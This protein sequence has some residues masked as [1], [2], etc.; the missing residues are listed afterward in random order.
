MK[1]NKLARSL[2][3]IGIGVQA[4]GLGWAQSGS[5]VQ[6]V[7]RVEITG[8]SI[9]RLAAEGALP[10][11]VITAEELSRKG[12]TTAEQMLS[13]M[14]INGTGADSAVANN[15]VFGNDTDRLTGGSANANLRGLGPGSTLV[16]LNG[17][18]VS[19]HGMSGGAVDLNAIPMAAVARV[20]VLKDGASAIYGTDAIGG[21]INFI[22]KKDMQGVDVAVTYSQP[23]ESSA[24]TR[25]R[26][27]VTG[28]FGN[29]DRDRFNFLG[30][31]TLDKDDILRGSDRKWATGFQPERYLS[32]DSSSHPFANI[33]GNSSTVS[34][35]ALGGVSGTAGSTIGTGDPTK[36][37]RINLL[38][39]QG[40]CD[41]IPTGVQYQPQL[42]GASAA[43][44][45]YICNTDYGAQ[46]MLAAPKDAYNLVARG[47]FL[48]SDSH[49]A[50]IELTASRTESKAELTPGQFSTT[51]AAQNHYPVNGPH[52]LNLKNYGVND[53]DPTKAIAYRWRMQ[54]F[55][56]RVIEN[57]SENQRLAAGLDGE[58]G[59]YSYKLGLSAAKAEGWSNLIDGYAYTAKLNAALK[60]GLINPWLKP[61]EKQTQAAMDL[62]ESTKARGRL[63][64][65]ETTLT[66]FDGALSGELLKLPAG[67]VDF[68]L[69]FD[70]RKES[71]EFAPAPDSFACV[72]GLSNGAN[73]VLLCPGNGE[74]RKQSR[75][76]RAVY[77]E[78]AVPVFKGLDLQLAVRHDQ[79]SKIGGTTNPKIAFRYQPNEMVL[80]RGSINTGFKAPSFQQLAPNMAPLLDTADWRDPQLCPT[81]DASNPN[82]ARRLDYVATGNPLLKPEKS[83][84][85]TIG[86]VISPLRDLTFYA[87]YWR[88]DLEDRLRKLT[89]NEVK[90]NYELFKDRFARDASGRVTL[91]T[92]GWENAADS[93]TKGLDWGATYQLKH[94]SGTWRTSINGT[95]M[96]SHKERALENQPLQEL[97]G[98]FALRTLYLRDKF[99][100]DLGWSRDDWST[101]LSAV[102]KSGYKDQDLSRFGTPRRNVSSYTTFNLFGSYSGIKNMVITAG[103]N[104]LF[105]KAPPFTYHNV[106]DVV[107][108]GWDPRVGDPFGRTLSLSVNYSFR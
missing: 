25:R 74:V 91:V 57:V 107:G 47:N 80:L 83:K 40:A 108:A 71:Y 81:V 34:G 7:E 3:L 26:A 95:H 61:G 46:S 50:F 13:Q 96:I 18:R 84:Q 55:G 93:S 38:S 64:G 15:N 2:A 36:Y 105:D 99:S 79:Y 39:L 72:S 33:V 19:T 76:V 30:S 77:G 97:V 10:V 37:T 86:I 102:Y 5:D 21:V 53:F 35:T 106:D 59:A 22:L 52:Y 66:Q 94:S 29:L 70:V 9:K 4:A 75:D 48:L 16:L 89:L 73:D 1:L 20:E 14:G 104:N 51:N 60:T 54:D 44:S 17:R 88:V 100:A 78:L 24:G 56:N 8:S 90:N 6:K 23:L 62:I 58:I 32:P 92:T 42:W 87:D 27:S 12:I 49:S 43:S 103:L 101:T 45:R 65:G 85:G 41:S 82:C 31:L 69:G 98:E 68:A 67:P 63:Q 28:G 11:Q